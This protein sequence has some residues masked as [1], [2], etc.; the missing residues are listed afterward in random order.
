MSKFQGMRRISLTVSL[1]LIITFAL[2]I[3]ADFAG[4]GGLG[5]IGPNQG[6]D[7][8]VL[9]FSQSYVL[10]TT[11]P[12]A[13]GIHGVNVFSL[14]NEGI[15]ATLDIEK[16]TLQPGTWL[17]LLWGAGGSVGG[18]GEANA[19]L[20]YGLTS[21]TGGIRAKI[22]VGGLS[23]FAR[24]LLIINLTS[25]SEENPLEFQLKI[26]TPVNVM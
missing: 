24:A 21:A 20:K 8:A 3:H 13:F 18:G 19:D 9:L 10:S 1:S 23:A 25:P 16:R 14:G 17:L 6:F 5:K 7:T 15:D 12:T 11:Q 22:K 2:L 4:A 26:E